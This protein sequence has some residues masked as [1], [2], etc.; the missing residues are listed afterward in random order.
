[1]SVLDSRVDRGGNGGC[2]AP[3]MAYRDV[4]SVLV[5]PDMLE[6]RCSQVRARAQRLA[7]YRLARH[8]RRLRRGIVAAALLLVIV[9]LFRAASVS[10]GVHLIGTA[11]EVVH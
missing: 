5:R 10:A 4:G 2:K 7:S 11:D 3:G 6:A 9:A 1:M 8:L